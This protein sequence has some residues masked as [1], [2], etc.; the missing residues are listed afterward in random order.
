MTRIATALLVLSVA[1]TAPAFGQGKGKEKAKRYEHDKQNVTHTTRSS[2][3]VQSGAPAF[4]RSGAG[5]PVYGRSWCVEKGFG[6]GTARWD[7]AVWNDAVFRNRRTAS[8]GDV[9]GSVILG[10]VSNYAAQRLGLRSPLNG[11][12]LVNSQD[13]TVYLVRSGTTPVAEF[14]DTN[15][16]GR[17]D[18]I[19]LHR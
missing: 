14:V 3:R 10:R 7:R 18:Y 2:A 1:V 12:W 6:L 11:S 5:H 17:A 8:I 15:Y 19:L 4:C 16:D 9:L 13:R